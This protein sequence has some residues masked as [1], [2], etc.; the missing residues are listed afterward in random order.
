MFWVLFLSVV[1]SVG[2]FYFTKNLF[3]TK[4][5]LS[6]VFIILFLLVGFFRASIFKPELFH[7]DPLSSLEGEEVEMS[8]EVLNSPARKE[9][10]LRA[11]GG[12]DQAGAPDVLLVFERDV[13]VDFGDKLFVRGTLKE[14]K[15]FET[16]QGKEFDYIGYLKKD[17]IKYILEVDS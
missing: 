7:E 11:K 2:V 1:F 17:G 5:G 13:E 6:F 9:F 16:D 8:V 3:I 4:S 12:V 10:S 15:N 14:P